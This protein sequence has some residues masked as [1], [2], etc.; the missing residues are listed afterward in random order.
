MFQVLDPQRAT[1]ARRRIN[2]PAVSNL[3]GLGHRRLQR[4][5]NLAA[6]LRDRPHAEAQAH[7]LVQQIADLALRQVITRAQHAH[8]RQ[9]PRAQLTLRH[10]GRQ[11]PCMRLAAD[12]AEAG[13]LRAYG[14]NP[15]PLLVGLGLRP[16]RLAM[17]PDDRFG[18]DV[19][20]T[21]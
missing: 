14:L 6:G 7:Q 3:G 15:E 8:Q 16:Q 13:G 20:R 19:G 9:R 5:G 10:P 18:R 2:G 12:L 1:G 11:H 4:A 21:P 17:L